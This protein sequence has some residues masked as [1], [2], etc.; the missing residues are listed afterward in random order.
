MGSKYIR[1]GLAL[2]SV[3]WLVALLAA[4]CARKAQVEEPLDFAQ[5]KRIA[6][7]E[8]K[9]ILVDFFANW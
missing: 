9:P 3:A 8:G 1:D 4:G 7:A 2:L 5:A 6:A